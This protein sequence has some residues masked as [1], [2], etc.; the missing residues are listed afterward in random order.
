MQIEARERKYNSL[1][2]AREFAVAQWFLTQQETCTREQW[3]LLETS[4]RA[5]QALGYEVSENNIHIIIGS[6]KRALVQYDWPHR[7]GGR[8]DI[9][10]A[11]ALQLKTVIQVINCLLEGRDPD[12]E[13]KQKWDALT[14]L[15]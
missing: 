1:G 9:E 5:T 8:V 13:L 12:P 4:K 14:R 11:S 3:G 6:H 2:R 15:V 10:R 7:G